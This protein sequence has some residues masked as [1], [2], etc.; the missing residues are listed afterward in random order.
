[1]DRNKILLVDDSKFFLRATAS[2]FEREGF[3]VLT[4]ATGEEALRVAQAEQPDLIMLD[5]LLPKL[6]GMMVLRMI[7][8]I[9]TLHETP[10]IVLSGNSSQ[11]DQ[12][13]ARELGI[14][15]YFLKDSTP[16]AKLVDLVRGSI[17]QR[18]S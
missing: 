6:D 11:Q 14:V 4:A 5:L 17:R 12:S 15:G 2:V 3:R 10:V 9:P 18:A 13:K 1:M 7:R 16:I 8:G